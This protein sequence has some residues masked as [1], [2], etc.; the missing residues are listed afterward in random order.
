M[1]TLLA[2]LLLFTGIPMSLMGQ[3]DLQDTIKKMDSL[4]FAAYNTCD[5]ETQAQ[6]YD[7]EIE[8]YHDSGGLVTD[9]AALLRSIEENICGKVSR[10]LLPGS[11]E[12][13]P[14]PGFGAVEIGK[15]SFVNHAEGGSRSEP[16]KFVVVWKDTPDGWKIYRVISLH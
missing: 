9:K 5:I 1:K 13:S 3:E 11:I 2:G 7:E 15:H 4:Y 6:F 14:I 12:V 10:E 16:S 8:F